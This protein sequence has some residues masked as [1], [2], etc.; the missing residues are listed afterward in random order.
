[1]LRDALVTYGATQREM[2]SALQWYI[3]HGVSDCVIDEPVNRFEIVNEISK[4]VEMSTISTGMPQ[5][6]QGQSQETMQRFLGKSDAY[7]EAVRLAKSANSLEELS[8]AISQFDGIAIKKTASNMV[9]ADGNPNADIMVI[10]EA[11]GADEDRQ[12]KPFVGESGQLLD[13]ILACIDLSRKSE[14]HKN[15]VYISN[16]LN[17]RPPGNRTPSPAEIEVSLPFIERH[18][19]LVKPKIIVL[20]GGV[21]AKSLLGS[22]NSISRLRGKWHDYMPQTKDLGDNNMS[23]PAIATYHPSYLLRTPVQK[24]L[25]WEDMLNLQKRLI[26]L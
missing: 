2:L 26:S 23:I 9:F 21:A 19:Q 1:M 16:I 15:S 24:K 22:G 6:L 18:I 10:G 8:E 3:D 4:P 14:D 25:V 7:E 12:G 13:K 20:C 5:Q 17:W 11:P